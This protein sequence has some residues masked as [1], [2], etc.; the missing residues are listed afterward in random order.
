MICPQANAKG[1][2]R[3]CAWEGGSRPLHGVWKV[4]LTLGVPALVARCFAL[5]QNWLL[6]QGGCF[7]IRQVFASFF[8]FWQP[9][10]GLLQKLQ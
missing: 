5:P 1:P 3:H 7:A 4:R 6:H 9:G 8:R 10:I 2:E